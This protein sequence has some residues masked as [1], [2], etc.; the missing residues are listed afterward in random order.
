[1]ILLKSGTLPQGVGEVYQAVEWGLV[2]ASDSR[3]SVV[4]LLD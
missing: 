1:M 3:V 4:H 2:P